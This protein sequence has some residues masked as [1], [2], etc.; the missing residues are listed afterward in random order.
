MDE[1]STV[2]ALVSLVRVTVRAAELSFPTPS[3]DFIVMLAG[4]VVPLTGLIVSVVSVVDSTV[5]PLAVYPAS[6][7]PP[8]SPAPERVRVSDVVYSL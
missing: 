3:T 1:I 6:R 4:N 8:V 7:L 5:T 2:G